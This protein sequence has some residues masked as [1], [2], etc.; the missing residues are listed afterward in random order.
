MEILDTMNS[1]KALL[2]TPATTDPP[3]LRKVLA[4]SLRGST[5]RFDIFHN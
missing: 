5:F 3:P 2:S 4:S 1:V